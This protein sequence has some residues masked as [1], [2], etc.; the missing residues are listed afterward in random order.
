MTR[1][2]TV[3]VADRGAYMSLPPPSPVFTPLAQESA[4]SQSPP[5]SAAVLADAG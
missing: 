1:R 3:A 5:A 2:S 4:S